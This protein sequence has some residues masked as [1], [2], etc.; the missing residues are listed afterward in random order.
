MSNIFLFFFESFLKEKIHRKIQFWQTDQKKKTIPNQKSKKLCLRNSLPAPALGL[1]YHE[2]LK[3]YVRC[4]CMWMSWKIQLA[5]LSSQAKGK[6]SF[7]PRIPP[8]GMGRIWVYKGALSTMNSLP[9]KVVNRNQTSIFMYPVVCLDVFKELFEAEQLMETDWVD[10]SEWMHFS[11]GFSPQ[12]YRFHHPSFGSWCA[13]L[14]KDN[15]ENPV[16]THW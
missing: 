3:N 16:T 2:T 11:V 12:N 14:Y 9:L 10:F 15:T 13:N 7:D 6:Q 1:C 5:A 8:N 4:K